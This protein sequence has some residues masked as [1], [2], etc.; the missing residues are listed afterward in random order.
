GP[1]VTGSYLNAD[2]EQ[3]KSF[4]D[5]WFRT[6]DIAH[7]SD[8]GYLTIIDRHADARRLGDLRQFHHRILEL[9]RGNPFP[10]GKDRIGE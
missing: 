4:D 9:H 8:D 3:D 1:Y 6:G 2:P 7:V 5:G 10:A